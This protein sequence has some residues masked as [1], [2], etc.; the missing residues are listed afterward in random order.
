[1]EKSGRTPVKSGWPITDN[2]TLRGRRSE[3]R[4]TKTA[5]AQKVVKL[6]AG[7]VKERADDEDFGIILILNGHI[8]V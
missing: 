3:H 8:T 4:F 1:M 7:T 2:F 5:G 6:L